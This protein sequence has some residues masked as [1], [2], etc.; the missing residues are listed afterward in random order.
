MI[1]R[2]SVFS[3]MATEDIKQTQQEEP[4]NCE[5]MHT[6]RI[7]QAVCPL[8]HGTYCITFAY[9]H[10]SCLLSSAWSVPSSSNRDRICAC[11]SPLLLQGEM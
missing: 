8:P 2:L 4:T 7:Y 3:E 5:Y 9:L 11:A 6:I 10:C 1:L